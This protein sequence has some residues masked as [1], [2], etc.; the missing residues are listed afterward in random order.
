MKNI[1]PIVSSSYEAFGFPVQNKPDQITYYYRRGITHTTGGGLFYRTFTGL[2]AP[3]ISDP[4]LIHSEVDNISGVSG[5]RM[6]DGSVIIFYVVT[7]ADG[8]RDIWMINGDADN[9]FG[10]PVMFDWNA[11]L[12]LTGGYFFGPMISGDVA[13]EYYHIIYQTATG[14]YRTSIVKTTDYWQTYSEIGVLYDGTIPFSET[15]GVNLGSGKFVAFSRQNN[16]GILIPF[17]S[18]N[19]GVTWIRRPSS[20]LYW[21][22]GGQ[23]CIPDVCFHDGVFDIFYECRDTS[24]MHISKGNTIADNFGKSTPVYNPQEIYCYHRG[25]G[26]NPSLGYGSQIQI[27]PFNGLYFIIFSKEYTSTRANLQWTIDDL[28]SDGSSQTSTINNNPTGVITITDPSPAAG[29]SYSIDG[30]NYDNTTGVFG[31]LSLGS[32]NIKAKSTTGTPI[33]PP[34]PVIVV[35]GIT[36][37]SFRID[38]TN[39]G[40]WQNVRYCLMD[41]S[42]QADF[43]TFVT[44]KYRTPSGYP[45]V[46]IHNI[47]VVGYYDLFSALITGTTYYLRVKAC[48]NEGESSYTIVN[49]TTL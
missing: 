32:Y 44:C 28:V 9:N 16:A 35:S 8:T 2:T 41:L 23:P 40:D 34:S 49:V 38:I 37:T 7:H 26:T 12:K 42:T 5:G 6:D 21:Y 29:I 14:R 25:T 39:Y 47:R 11:V 19:Y 20:T 27:K 10:A 1:Q 43:S 30:I 13:G 45:A 48:N 33:L 22:V 31:N 18:T 4:I 17:E 46:P 24:M 15:A 3:V 36:T